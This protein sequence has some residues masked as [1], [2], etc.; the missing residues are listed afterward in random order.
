MKAKMTNLEMAAEIQKFLQTCPKFYT[1][2][3]FWM[4]KFDI[5][6]FRLADIMDLIDIDDHK[7][8]RLMTTA[9]II[10]KC[11]RKEEGMPGP[12]FFKLARSLNY[13]TGVTK[14]DECTFWKTQLS[15][16]PENGIFL[17]V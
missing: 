17:I 2:Y 16:L 6:R 9:R 5:D 7:A 3:N 13:M 15:V 11:A 1:N 4:E 10:Q 8:G 12:G 14:D